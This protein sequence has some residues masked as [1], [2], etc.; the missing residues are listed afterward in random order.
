MQRIAIL[1]AGIS[2]LSAAWY[3]K[4]LLGSSVQLTVLE[5]KLVPRG[6]DSYITIRRF[7]F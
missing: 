2:G 5:K 4:R 6:L 7:S 3:L 1:G